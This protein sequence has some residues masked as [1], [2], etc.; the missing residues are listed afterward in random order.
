MNAK[1]REVRR[2]KKKKGIEAERAKPLSPIDALTGEEE[3][4]GWQT[5]K[6]C[7]NMYVWLCNSLAYARV[8]GG[9]CELLRIDV[10]VRSGI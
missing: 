10:G 3:W 7:N 4:S 9:K 8:K 6:Y 2:V 1:E 5:I